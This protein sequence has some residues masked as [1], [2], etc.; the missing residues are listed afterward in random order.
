MAFAVGLLAI[1][2]ANGSGPFAI[3]FARSPDFYIGVLFA[4]A[5]K[6]GRDQTCWCLGDGRGV[7]FGEGSRLV[8]EFVFEDAGAKGSGFFGSEL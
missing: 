7:A 8:D 1:G 5:T 2:N 4:C 3:D 6:P